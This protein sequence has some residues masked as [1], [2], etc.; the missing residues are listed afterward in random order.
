MFRPVKKLG[1][2]QLEVQ[3]WQEGA[4]KVAEQAWMADLGWNGDR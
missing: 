3:A 1:Y 4:D 2:V